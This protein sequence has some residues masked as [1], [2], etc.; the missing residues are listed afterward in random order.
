MCLWYRH[1][2]IEY[3]NPTIERFS[4]HTTNYSMEE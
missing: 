3:G 1:D 4:C 2:D